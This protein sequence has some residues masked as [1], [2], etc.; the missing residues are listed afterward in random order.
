M[1]ANESR[2]T[3]ACASSVPHPHN[4]QD[5]AQGAVGG[6]SRRHNRGGVVGEGADRSLRDG[7]RFFGG[8]HDGNTPSERST[9]TG[10]S[11]DGEGALVWLVGSCLC[12]AAFFAG[13][14]WL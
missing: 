6:H 12:I 9:L 8:D 10:K 14:V 11:T 5:S 2:R 7:R 13:A 4:S 1:R 3:E